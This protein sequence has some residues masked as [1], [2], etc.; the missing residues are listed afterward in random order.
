VIKSGVN[1][2][3]LPWTHTY[4]FNHALFCENYTHILNWENDSVE[5]NAVTVSVLG[6]KYANYR[7]RWFSIPYN[8]ILLS[9]G[10]PFGANRGMSD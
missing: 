7:L 6:V 3:Y 4:T 10:C 8:L 9:A 5:I 2:A 1:F